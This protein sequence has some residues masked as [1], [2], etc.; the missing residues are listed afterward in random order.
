MMFYGSISP[1]RTILWSNNAA[2]S[3]FWVNKILRRKDVK[4]AKKRNKSFQPVRNYFDKK[5]HKR[6][7]GTPDLTKTGSLGFQ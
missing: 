4:K 7:T 5:G 3:G 6:F 2:I 1:K